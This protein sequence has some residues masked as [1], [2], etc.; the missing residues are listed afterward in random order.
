MAKRFFLGES[1][2]REIADT[3]L[4]FGQTGE[5]VSKERDRM[6]ADH[7]FAF[8]HREHGPQHPLILCVWLAEVEIRHRRVSSAET[9]KT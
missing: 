1:E 2:N 9:P 8:V 6:L 5:V 3:S 7:F 4:T